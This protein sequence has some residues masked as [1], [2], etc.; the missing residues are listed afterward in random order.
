[1]EP[2]DRLGPYEIVAFIGAGGMGEVW[3]ARDTRLEREVAL[4]VLPAKTVADPTARARLLREARL[5]SQLNHP[6]VCTI[7]E[8]GETDGRAYIAMELVEGR[9]LASML[10]GGGLPAEQV[11]KLG[12]QLADALAHAHERGV[13]HRDLKSGNVNVTLEGRVKVLDFGLARRLA[14]EGAAVAT[15]LTQA[16]LTEAGA[17]VGTLAYM[18]PEQLRG[19]GADARSDVWALGVVLYEMAAGRRPFLGDTGYQLSSAILSQPPAPLPAAVPAPLAAAIGRCLAK[20]PAQ[21]YQRGGEV[22]AALEAVASGETPPPWP[23]LRAWVVCHRGQ[24]LLTCASALLAVLV[25]L[26]V[27]GV[28]SR[29][30][31]GPGGA[32]AIRMAVLPFANLSG[33]PQQDY[34]S[35]GLTQE[36]IAQ[37]GRLHPETL[38]VIARTSVMR[39]KKTETPIDQI[40]RELG[41][42]YVLEGSAQREGSRVKVSAE[43]IQVKN[44]AQL[45]ADTYER[46]LAGALV[47]ESEVA[48]KVASALAL[49]LLPAEQTRLASVHRVNPEA[50]DAYLKAA[51]YW[52]RLTPQDL[53]TAERLLTVALEKDPGYAR[54]YAGIALVW[55]CRQQLGYAKP[56]EAGPKARAAARRAVE[57]DD[58]VAEA[59][60]ALADILTWTDWNWAAA[61]R[62]WERAVELG[63]GDA[64]AIATYSHY[65]TI[66]GRRDEAMRQIERA[67]ELDPFNV[68]TVTFYAIDLYCA[69]RYDEAIAQARKALSLQPD[70]PIAL[71]ALIAALHETKQHDEM[72]AAAE[73]LYAAWCPDVGQALERGYAGRDYAGAWRHAV[74]VEVGRHGEGPGAA[75]DITQNY[76]FVGDTAH[77]LDWLEKAYDDRDPSM[78]YIGCMPIFDPLRSEPRFQALVRK[79]GLPEA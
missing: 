57:L 6:N 13:V 73:K 33:D 64:V 55:A 69:R 24:T 4:K 71:G 11:L 27:G 36:M 53:D 41:V 37:L 8:V 3:R 14:S 10:A 74:E 76:L 67:V 47:L 72:I 66:V 51:S 50:Y 34:L 70:S 43:L 26:D 12:L 58:S 30:L 32:Q 54:G 77:A 45:W 63:P 23:A 9:S 49:K 62:E 20:A 22:R 35:D 38:S 46:E 7:H 1:M 2:G 44:Q 5:A 25:G 59:H 65:L 19:E 18:A 61:A 42:D 39:Y 68:L 79:L 21:R 16:S 52:V 48:R 40:G 31:G 17:I 29:V 28:R 15:T 78:P 56:G 75:W 60:F